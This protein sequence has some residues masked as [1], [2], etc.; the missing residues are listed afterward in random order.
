MAQ[1][2]ALGVAGETQG[3][4][5]TQRLERML[6]ALPHAVFDKVEKKVFR[7]A[8]LTVLLIA[9]I[10]QFVGW[11]YVGVVV[12]EG[13]ATVQDRLLPWVGP[14]T[15]DP[16][17]PG[18]GRVATLLLG[19]E[20]FADREGFDHRVPPP[21]QRLQE[22]LDAA[23]RRLLAREDQKPRLMVLDF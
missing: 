22:L 11:V 19:D 17:R 9:A 2:G 12:R 15:Q 21:P 10:Q 6:T 14:D 4:T 20:I 5:R 3:P 16:L 23:L 7:V 13:V 1:G 8:F 18:G